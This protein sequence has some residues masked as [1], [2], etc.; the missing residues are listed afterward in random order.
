MVSVTDGND[1]IVDG[2]LFDRTQGLTTHP[3]RPFPTAG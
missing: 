3:I 2:G 1:D